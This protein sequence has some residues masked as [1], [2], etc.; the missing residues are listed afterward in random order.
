MGEKGCMGLK[1]SFRGFMGLWWVMGMEKSSNRLRS[2]G[3]DDLK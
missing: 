3:G 2:E 1:M